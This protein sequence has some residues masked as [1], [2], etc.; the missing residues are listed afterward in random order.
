MVKKSRSVVLK[1]M[2]AAPPAEPAA[3]AD[4]L[5]SEEETGRLASLLQN[6]GAEVEV[7]WQ[8]GGHQL[9]QG[10]VTLAR[11]WFSRATTKSARETS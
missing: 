4:P 1:A 7:A 6:A 8:P 9:S 2:L 3:L 5:V 11:E 10:D